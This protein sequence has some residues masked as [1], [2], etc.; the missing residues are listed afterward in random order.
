MGRVGGR[1]SPDSRTPGRCETRAY[2]SPVANAST[3]REAARG[4]EVGAREFR[5][6]VRSQH[7]GF[8]EAVIADTHVTSRAR[9]RPLAGASRGRVLLE[10]ARLA[11][12]S[13]GFLAQLMYRAKA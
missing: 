3:P 5:R 9:G 2:A 13:D 7:P 4:A 12:R 10:A 1:R 8:L 6:M 11:Y